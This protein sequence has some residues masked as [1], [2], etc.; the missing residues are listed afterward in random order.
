MATT[1]SLPLLL[2]PVSLSSSGF[3]T[4]GINEGNV[5]SFQLYSSS[6]SRVSNAFNV[7]F[8]LI[9]KIL[10]FINVIVQNPTKE[11]N[12]SFSSD[13]RLVFDSFIGN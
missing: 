3:G 8:P 2:S 5:T 11:S 9:A 10:E 1:M 12:N 6:S 13:L 7:C 4:T